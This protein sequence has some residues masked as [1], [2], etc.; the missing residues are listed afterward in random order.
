MKTEGKR[1]KQKRWRRDSWDFC[2]CKSLAVK[3]CT[4]NPVID[5]RVGKLAVLDLL[6]EM[7]HWHKPNSLY[8]LCRHLT[9]SHGAEEAQTRFGHI[10]EGEREA[11][12]RRD[13][14]E[15]IFLTLT[16]NEKVRSGSKLVFSKRQ[17]R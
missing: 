17:G 13:G 2:G 5:K 4:G 8:L 1:S 11:I 10:R 6:L 7:H 16:K 3:G 14:F 12:R 15:I 9:Q